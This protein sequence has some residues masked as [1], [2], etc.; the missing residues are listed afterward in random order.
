M[1]RSVSL[2]SL[3]AAWPDKMEAGA[4]VPWGSLLNSEQTPMLENT[5]KGVEG[6]ARGDACGVYSSIAYLSIW[7]PLFTANY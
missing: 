7:H 4:A 5:W 3:Q 2:R 6:P 1:N